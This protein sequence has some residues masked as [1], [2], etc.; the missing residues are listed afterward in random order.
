MEEDSIFPSISFQLF[1]SY[2]D[3]FNESRSVL[4]FS[5]RGSPIF[6]SEGRSTSEHVVHEGPQ[7]PPVHRLAVPGPGQNLRRHVLD[8]AAE[9]VGHCALVNGLLAQ[10]KVCQLN[11]TL[12]VKQ[13]ILRLEIPVDDSLYTNENKICSRAWNIKIP[14]D[15]NALEPK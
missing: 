14:A 5:R 10:T 6:G 13:N 9:G 12:S 3:R 2:K 1:F 4:L 11:M 15:A 7:G 8:S